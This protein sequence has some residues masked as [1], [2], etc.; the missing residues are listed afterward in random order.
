M[1]FAQ[2]A[3]V[4]DVR[5]GADDGFHSE[6]MTAE[7]VQD[8]RDFVAGVHHQR[9]ARHRVAD[10]RAVALQHPYGD[11]DMDQ[12]VRG[13]IESWPAVAHE[14]EYIIGEE[15]ICGRRCT[16]SGAL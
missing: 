3:D 1:K 9:F 11:G 14:V 10:D 2:P 12:S 4:I 8:A 16:V 5:M 7:K 13:G 15:G 6:L